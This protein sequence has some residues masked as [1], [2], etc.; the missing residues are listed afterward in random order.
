MQHAYLHTR[1]GCPAL[2]ELKLVQI[3]LTAQRVTEMAKAAF[4][5]HLVT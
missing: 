1:A 5:Q 3:P 4:L 2:V